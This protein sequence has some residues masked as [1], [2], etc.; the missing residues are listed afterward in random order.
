MNLIHNYSN[1]KKLD[2]F[3]A[4]DDNVQKIYDKFRLDLL[5]AIQQTHPE[6][7]NENVIEQAK[8]KYQQNLKLVEEANQDLQNIK[9]RG[10]N[11][12][13][14]RL[15]E[16]LQDFCNIKEAVKI[17]PGFQDIITDAEENFNN[18][19]NQKLKGLTNN[20]LDELEKNLADYMA[21]IDLNNEQSNFNLEPSL[22]ISSNNQYQ[23]CQE[24][25]YL[26][27]L[28]DWKQYDQKEQHLI[29]DTNQIQSKLLEINQEPVNVNNN[30]T[31]FGIGVK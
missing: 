29:G 30:S 21:M 8:D 31:G 13:E 7:I 20:N 19:L 16:I 23:E 2:K 14:A 24:E 6:A 12:L 11:N 9:P 26:F 27:D 18:A 1:A 10:S 28:I 15:G 3:E 25:Q 4:I 22:N 5:L 17:N